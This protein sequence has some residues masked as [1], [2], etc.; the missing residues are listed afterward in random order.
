V[1]NRKPNISVDV[2]KRVNSAVK[3]LKYRVNLRAKSLVQNSSNIV[4][5]IAADITNP[6]ISIFI[7]AL[8]ARFH[9][10][11]VGILLGNS[12]NDIH[13]EFEFIDLFTARKARG[14]IFTGEK[15]TEE[16]VKKLNICNIPILVVDQD[17]EELNCPAIVFDNYQA[18]YDVVKLLIKKG[19]RD[20][21][22]ISCPTEDKHAGFLRQK[23]YRDA[24]FDNGIQLNRALLQYAEFTMESGY[25]AMEKMIK[26]FKSIPSVIFGATDNIA[27]G[28]MKY[29]HEKEYSI[30]GDISVFGFDNI[31]VSS[32]LI[33]SLSSV[34]LDHYKSGIFAAD[35][36]FQMTDSKFPDGIKK[37]IFKHKIILRESC[38]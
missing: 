38:R 26:N 13:K 35:L 29:L 21:G 15:I 27:I 31:P 32:K 1:I 19:H 17:H 20:I 25:K 37:V 24:L 34:E 12:R 30:P 36:F 5:V 11:G 16:H 4:G 18:S 3:K 28:A 7:D 2:Q 33:P 6:P 22:F 8:S 23:G 14:I 10:K 9:E